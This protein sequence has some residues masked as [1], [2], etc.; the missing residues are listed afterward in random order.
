MS[1]KKHSF[2][3]K[4][5]AARRGSASAYSAAHHDLEKET[6]LREDVTIVTTDP[7]PRSVV[8]ITE[9]LL[10]KASRVGGGSLSGI[11]TLNLHLP[12]RTSSRQF[13][14][15]KYL[16]NFHLCPIYEF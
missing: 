14:Q 13:G 10:R 11:K 7:D 4:T 1:A 6:D 16:E 5:S 8:Y 9:R 12:K 15:I 3:S 2:E